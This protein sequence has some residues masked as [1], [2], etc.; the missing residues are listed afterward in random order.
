M[1]STWFAH[2]E[3]LLT[4]LVVPTA[5]A[6]MLFAHW[7]RQQLT[8]RLANPLLLR[9]SVLTRPSVRRAKA[10]CLL[11]GM[12]LLS[13][14]CA[15]PQWGL[16]NTGQVRKGRDVVLV[17]DLSRS[18]S[19]EQPSRRKLALRALRHLADTFEE[20]GGN[21][22][23]LVAFAAQPRLLFPLTHDCDHLR[24]TLQQIEADDIPK[25][26]IDEPISGT[27]IGAALKLA[28]AASDPA[29]TNRP[30]VVL[31]SDGDDP[32]D[33]G[34]WLQG[35]AAAK[36]INLRVHVVGI[37]D[38]HREETIPAG[39]DIVEFEGK[40]VRTKLNEKLLREITSKTGGEYLPAHTQTFPLGAF[41]LHLLDADELREEIPSTDALPVYQLRYAWFLWPALVFFMLTM[42]F[43]EGPAAMKRQPLHQARSNTLRT[44]AAA[45]LLAAIAI[46]GVSAA[47][48]PDAE[49]LVR[50]GTDAF[51]RQEY[52]EA[53][54]SFE[55]AE[56]LTHDPGWVSFN[57]AAAHFRLGQYRDAIDCYRRSLED[58]SAPPER[59]AR[60]RF[61]LGN[62]LVQYATEQPLPLADAVASYRAC[63]LE[64]SL[65][66]KLRADARHN[67]EI[68]QV[69][70]LKAVQAQAKEG[71]PPKQK[72]P[73]YPEKPDEKDPN[74]A[75][76]AYDVPADP[77]PGQEVRKPS[78]GKPGGKSDKLSS[79]ALLT[80]PDTEQIQPLSPDMT[81]E[82]IAARAR[83]IAAARR[84]QR[85]PPGPASLSTKDW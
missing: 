67:L 4:L 51:A 31:L 41:V 13:I 74:A 59:R 58:D 25:L 39:R 34:E 18:M 73:K 8:A 28:A 72:D 22:V 56:R 7:R 52:A 50:Q 76:K 11:I 24:H 78:T 44:K 84:M 40:P 64:P 70:W 33:D 46:C 54:K 16:D 15:G 47:D 1:L 57:K 75:R 9:K 32:V 26:S 63:L 12:T 69:L 43:D 77:G 83:R 65:P 62:A 2:P 42:L 37:G 55:Q 19:A 5:A 20:H 45:L 81:L 82:Q 27:R 17:L 6:L 14:A 10:I 35:V 38:P 49:A 21:R 48:S 85:N 79:Q 66:D 3:F 60:A 29:R 80:L 36:E 30:V 68:A 53:I 71:G 23:A 61:D